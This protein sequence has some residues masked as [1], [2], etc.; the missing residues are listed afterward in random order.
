MCLKNKCSGIK[1]K[2]FKQEN[3]LEKIGLTP[4]NSHVID[5]DFLF[6]SEKTSCKIFRYTIFDLSN[7]HQL[8]TIL[9][10]IL[11]YLN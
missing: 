2:K 3:L 4:L 9:I 11:V 7:F 1:S 8:D 10:N 5:I 6:F